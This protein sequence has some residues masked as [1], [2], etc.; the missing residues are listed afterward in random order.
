MAHI[1]ADPYD[2]LPLELLAKICYS[3]TDKER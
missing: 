2:I 3:L 1:I